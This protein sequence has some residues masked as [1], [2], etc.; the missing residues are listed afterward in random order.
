MVYRGGMEWEQVVEAWS[1]DDSTDQTW[2]TVT[3]AER[4]SGVSR[5]ALR[6]WYRDGQIPSRVTDGPF[7]PQR[8][9]PVEAVLERVSQSPRLRGRAAAP[10]QQLEAR[11]AAVEAELARLRR[12]VDRLSAGQG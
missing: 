12:L 6:R 1:R 11:L 7:G 9:V 8:M 10:G 5:S 2:V 4:A 3:E